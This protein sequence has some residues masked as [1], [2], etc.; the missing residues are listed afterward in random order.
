MNDEI[1]TP[2]EGDIPSDPTE[3]RLG[4]EATPI[5]IDAMHDEIMADITSAIGRGMALGRDHAKEAQ[6]HILKNGLHMR[7]TFW[8]ALNERAIEVIEKEGDSPLLAIVEAG[9]RIITIRFRDD[10]SKA[11][12][13]QAASAAHEDRAESIE[14]AKQQYGTDDVLVLDEITLAGPDADRAIERYITTA[15]NHD[16]VEDAEDCQVCS[17][18]LARMRAW[19]DAV[20]AKRAAEESG[21]SGD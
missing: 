17:I 3:H 5:D 19:R 20:R 12:P 21:E 10:F 16:T 14:I 11:N 1:P 7:D 13:L 6:E 8:D 9:Y 15:T 18:T 2:A 4:L